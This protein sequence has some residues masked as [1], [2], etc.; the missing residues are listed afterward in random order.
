MA[1]TTYSAGHRLIVRRTRLTD[2]QPALFPTF[3]YHA[4]VTDH[5]RHVVVELAIRDPK[6]GSGLSH[7][8]SGRSGAN[9]A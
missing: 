8:P 1:E 4:F 2:P 9:S 6:Q 3:R 7:C 5:R